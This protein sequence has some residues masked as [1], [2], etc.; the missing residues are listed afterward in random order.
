MMFTTFK[1]TA[2]LKTV[3]S[4][5]YFDLLGVVKVICL[6]PLTSALFA[7]DKCQNIPVKL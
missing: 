1:V 7:P 6:I 2:L 4:L 3:I 5:M